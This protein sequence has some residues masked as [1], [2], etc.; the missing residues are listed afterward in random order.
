ML[1]FARVESPNRAIFQIYLPRLSEENRYMSSIFVLRY[2]APTI[3]FPK[4][5]KSITSTM[6]AVQAK[7]NKCLAN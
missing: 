2:T 1:S 7:G 5:K 3:Q 6:Q 4:E